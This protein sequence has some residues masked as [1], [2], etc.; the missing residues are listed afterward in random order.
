[1]RVQQFKVQGSMFLDSKMIIAA[2][3]DVGKHRD[4][5][6]QGRMVIRPLYWVRALKLKYTNPT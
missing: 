6:L 5:P 4:A 1:M 2:I 3:I